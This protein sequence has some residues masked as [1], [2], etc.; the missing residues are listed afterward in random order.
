MN[1]TE[2]GAFA[3]QIAADYLE[4]EGYNILDRN[5]RYKRLGEI[6]IV[7]RFNGTIIFVEVRYRTSTV[8]GTP[9]ESLRPGKIR[10]VRRTALMWL[11]VHGCHHLPC[12]CDVIAVDLVGGEPVV[13]HLVDAF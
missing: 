10:K 4:R 12:R 9:E 8:Y 5:Y 11:T 2:V 6:D 7:A 13:R 3:E 1:T